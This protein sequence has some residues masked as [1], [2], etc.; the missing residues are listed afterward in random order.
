M[1]RMVNRRMTAIEDFLGKLRKH[2]E[3]RGI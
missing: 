2:M 3:A 1:E